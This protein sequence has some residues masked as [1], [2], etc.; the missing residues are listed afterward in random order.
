MT[1]IFAERIEDVLNEMLPGLVAS[2]ET[3]KVPAE[4]V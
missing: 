2:A 1:F 4:A 3:E